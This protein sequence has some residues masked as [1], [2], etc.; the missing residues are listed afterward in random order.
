MHSWSAE[1]SLT[2]LVV[3]SALCSIFASVVT[4]AQT[5]QEHAQ[6]RWPDRANYTAAVPSEKRN[7]FN[8]AEP[9]SCRVSMKSTSANSRSTTSNKAVAENPVITQ[10]K[11]TGALERISL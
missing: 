11:Q 1:I 10:M 4:A 7:F 2:A 9:M 8:G 6:A 3:L 5:W